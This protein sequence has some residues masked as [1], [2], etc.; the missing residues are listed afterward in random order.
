MVYEDVGFQ[1]EE[2]IAYVTLNRPDKR[3]A[4][5]R[6]VLQQLTILLQDIGQKREV[7]VVVIKA[8]GKV[9]SAGHDLS[10]VAQASPQE[11]L[12]LVRVC[13]DTMRAIRE[14]PQ[15]VIAQVHGLA[16][17]AGCQLVAA[18]DLAVAA[19]DAFFATPGV[20][21]GLFCTTPSVFLSRNIG[22][23]KALEM[24]FTGEPITAEEAMACGLVNKV[25]APGDLENATRTMAASIAGYG[26]SAIAVGKR[27]F[28]QQLNM[29]DFVALN[30]A[31]E[32]IALNTTT[33]DC[34]E[35]IQAFLEKRE[36]HWTGS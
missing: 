16:T 32:V 5:S 4:L 22:R 19:S 15:P 17:A 13:F 3:N 29:E 35:G 23:K 14:I 1:V 26:L 28:Y 6:A 34:R 30:Y 12:D 10:E 8:V 25:V 2:K 27:A 24:L 36:P 11:M 33:N 21:I 18:C 7:N 9:F 31:S 20:K